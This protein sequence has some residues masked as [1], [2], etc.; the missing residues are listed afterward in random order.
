[1]SFLCSSS[2]L[3]LRRRGLAVGVKAPLEWQ[4]TRRAFSSRFSNAR[5][6][7][8]ELLEKEPEQQNAPNATG[9]YFQ[10]P[11]QGA[12][13]SSAFPSYA[14]QRDQRTG[15]TY[16][17]LTTGAVEHM[18]KV[19]GTLATGVGIAAGASLLTLGTPLMAMHP[20]IPGLAAIVPL[21][22]I[23]YTSKHTMSSTARAGLFAAFTGLSGV[24]MA[25]LIG[26]ALK[27]SPVLVPQALLITTGIFGAMTALSLMAKPGA[28]LRWG[29]PLGG[30]LLVLMALGIGSMFVPVTSAWY[31]L[32]HSVQLYGGLALFTAYVA[33]DTQKMIDEYE[34]G[35]D[36]HI[37]HATDLFIDF[38]VIFTRI[39][40]LLM[41]RD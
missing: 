41:N 8:V 16:D 31:P 25:P 29:V 30:G 35:E 40:A 3:L 24:A 10:Q 6:K 18:R 7:K 32:L 4:C 17:N 12:A 36:D 19:Y 37:K 21:M 1:M 15:T 11:Q 23:M 38:K 33:Y 2:S 13:P 34:M 14:D 26:L 9:S 22:G 20:M 39:L 5:K 27:M 28:T